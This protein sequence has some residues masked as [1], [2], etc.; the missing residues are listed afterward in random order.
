MFDSSTVEAIADLSKQADKGNLIHPVTLENGQTYTFQIDTTQHGTKIGALLK[1]PVEAVLTV[2]TLTGL[3]DAIAATGMMPDG[4]L[5]HVEDYKT[6]HLKNRLNDNWGNRT[7]WITAKHSPVTKFV[8]DKY[9]SD[10]QEFIIQLQSSF[11]QTEEMLYLIRVAS[12]LKAGNSVHASDDGFSQTVTIKTGEV[13]TAEVE[14]RPRIKLIPMRTF[15]EA[16][17]VSSE[18]LIRFQQTGNGAPSI[19]LFDLEGKKW[20]GELMG[21]VKNWLKSQVKGDFPIIA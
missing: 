4:L 11:Y 16:S 1:P 7:T 18:F 2:T 21:S 17:P 8:F 12:S 19:A 3:R 5:I 9:Y 15:P 10:P 13:T 6:V 20:E 14:I